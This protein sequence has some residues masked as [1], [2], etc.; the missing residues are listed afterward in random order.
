MKRFW[1]QLSENDTIAKTQMEAIRPLI[2]GWACLEVFNNEILSDRTIEFNLDN[3]KWFWGLT[4]TTK[5][6]T[7]KVS[8]E[9]AIE[10]LSKKEEFQVGDWVVTIINNGTFPRNTIARIKEDCG[11]GT[12]AVATDYDYWYYR[13]RHIRKATKE[14]IETH[15]IKEAH[16]RGFKP[17]VKIKR[18]HLWSDCNNQDVTLKKSYHPGYNHVEDRLDFCSVYVYNKGKWAEIIDEEVLTLNSGIVLTHEDIVKIK[19]VMDTIK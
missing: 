17:G 19:K 7:P 14:E 11:D 12:L 2:K 13:P 6:N 16:K 3:K 9:E 4:S 15:L 1:I 10:R 18:S 8:V 5:E